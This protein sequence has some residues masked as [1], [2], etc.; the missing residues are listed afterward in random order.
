MVIRAIPFNVRSLEDLNLPT[1]LKKITAYERGLTAP[2]T[3]SGV[4]FPLNLTM[5]AT[6]VIHP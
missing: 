2:S 4:P 3:G 6:G 5:Q 1:V